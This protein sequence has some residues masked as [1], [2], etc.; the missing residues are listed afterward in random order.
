MTHNYNATG[1]LE[2]HL[3]PK[4][5][6]RCRVILVVQQ[7]FSSLA[8]IACT[9]NAVL[10]IILRK[11][12][13]TTGK[14]IFWLSVSSVLRSLVFLLTDHDDRDCRVKGFF[15][16][17]FSCTSLLWVFMIAVNCLLIVKRKNHKHYFIWY[18]I[19]VWLGSMVWS[20]IPFFSDSYGHAG[21]WCWIGLETDVRFGMWYVPLFILCFCMILIY[22]YLLRFVMKFQKPLNNRSDDERT[23]QKRM[24]RDLKSLLTYPFFY[25]LFSIPI[26]IYRLNDAADPH[27]K[28]NYGVTIASVLLTP[29]LGV[30]YTVAFVLI[31]ANLKE[32]S[33]PL[34]R[35]GLRDIFRKI[36]RHA[37]NYN[38][39]VN[40]LTR[41]SI[42]SRQY[43][44][45]ESA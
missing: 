28:P 45:N 39:Q 34:L 2:C 8:L 43:Q 44:P 19:I 16:N 31:N 21:L 40:S 37:V 7:T 36:P 32:I 15:H 22:V 4:D 17:Y 13:S 23:A 3:W 11:Y 42:K 18:H 24:R 29:L 35:E 5:P 26:F 25:I 41:L 12:K 6:N 38:F 20:T 1:A 27:R 9:I 30:V 14:L 10:I 33:I